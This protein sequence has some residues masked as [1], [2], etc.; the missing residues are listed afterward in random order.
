MGVPR[1]SI[2]IPAYNRARLLRRSIGSV[3]AQTDDDFEVVVVDDGSTDDTAAVVE[4]FP[5]ARVRYL[6]QP[7]S[8]VSKAR[9]H[10]AASA[11][12]VHLVF[13]D[14]DDELLPC[15]LARFRQELDA[16]ASAVVLSGWI[17]VSADRSVWRTAVPGGPG[18]PEHGLFLAG[19]FAVARELFTAVGGYD[20]QLRFA[21]NS[22]LGWRLRARIGASGRRL[23]I[24]T[25]PLVVLYAQP[26]RPYHDAKY[27]AAK[28]VLAGAAAE[29]GLDGAVGALPARRRR[30]TYQAIAGVSA[31]RLGHR[32]EALRYTAAAVRNDPRSPAR[33]RALL[34]VTRALVTGRTPPDQRGDAPS[35]ADPSPRTVEPGAIHAVLVTFGRPDSLAAMVDRLPREGLA[36]LTVVDNAPSVASKAAAHRAASRLPTT[37]FP[38]AENIG[39]AGG[40][41]AGMAQ[42]SC[43]ASVDDWVLVLNDDGVRGPDGTITQLRTFGKWLLERGAPVGAV[44]LLGARFD[45]R[46]GR[47]RRPHDRELAGP[48]TVD[49]V[50]GGQLLMVRVDALRRTGVFDPTLFFGFEELDFCLRLR[51]NGFGI[52][53]YGP[54]WY[55]TRRKF[56]RL[57]DDVARP[58]RLKSPW[59]RYYS[60]RNH[61]VVMRRY[62]SPGGALRVTAEHLL[63][64]PL[65]ELRRRS[66]GSL[67]MITAGTRGCVDAWRDRL[68]RTVEPTG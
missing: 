24:V 54:A 49:Y 20:D 68:G 50:A 58:E 60:V 2:I 17:D 65:V 51:R 55:E 53:A 8:G 12:G 39:P 37:Y 4:S 11:R 56:G 31:S 38:M 26:R 62:G 3:L 16:T 45:A 28:R 6:P 30:A 10:G 27:E 15:A 67:A 19:T 57:G 46:T 59:R 36:S 52:Y 32:R 1:F 40:L 64:R 63:G 43:V 7:R 35:I 47:L 21:E 33:Y 48:V 14:S 13:L 5:D 22:E 42:A 9:N 61:V 34:G 44:G 18:V 25:A 41:A 66:P 23:P 29:G